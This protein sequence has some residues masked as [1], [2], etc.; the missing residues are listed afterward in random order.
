MGETSSKE[1]EVSSTENQDELFSKHFSSK[2]SQSQFKIRKINPSEVTALVQSRNLECANRETVGGWDIGEFDRDSIYLYMDS[3]DN[4]TYCFSKL[5]AGLLNG[6]N[7]YTGKPF[8]TDITRSLF[9]MKLSPPLSFYSRRMCPIFESVASGHVYVT[10]SERQGV[11]YLVD[12]AA[13]YS[14]MKVYRGILKSSLLSP[15]FHSSNFA[16]LKLVYDGSSNLPRT[17][18]IASAKGSGLII[19]GEPPA[20]LDQSLLKPGRSI[21][22]ELQGYMSNPGLSLSPGSVS[23]LRSQNIRLDSAQVVYRGFSF[24]FPKWSVSLDE[25]IKIE[26]L[27]DSS[28]WT[29]NQCIAEFFAGN[30]YLKPKNSK[31]RFGYVVRWEAQPDEIV[32][33]TRLLKTEVLDSLTL[34]GADQA[35]LL[36]DKRERTV[37]IVALFINGEYV[38]RIN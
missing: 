32:I 23:T 6:D 26:D 30:G 18:S 3:S 22:L 36:L 24:D 27:S 8:N 2:E 1:S 14:A 34:T 7:P 9:E 29:A 20:D 10:K 16:E 31:K 11:Y 17:R 12:R 4:K 15:P 5:D 37:T 33:D 13:S 19:I 38:R 21:F 25:E 35:E 28:S